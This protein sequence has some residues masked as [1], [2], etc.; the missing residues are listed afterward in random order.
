MPGPMS[1]ILWPLRAGV[2]AGGVLVK[3]AQE[4]IPNGGAGAEDAFVAPAQAPPTRRPAA[5]GTPGP[6]A[7][8]HV[9]EDPVPVATVADPGAAAGA[10]PE[11]EI[12]EPWE[13]YDTMPVSHIADQLAAAPVEAAAA[14]RLYETANLSR[15]T[16]LDATEVRLR[17][18]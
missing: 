3:V 5:R 9:S 2:R 1:L 15:R 11:L 7:P 10:G 4:L 13:G 12:A 17:R 18:G 8:P 14:V 6:P 16:I